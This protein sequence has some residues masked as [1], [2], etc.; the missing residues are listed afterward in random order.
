MIS[1]TLFQSNIWNVWG[2]HQGYICGSM[3]TTSAEEQSVMRTDWVTKLGILNFEDL[4]GRFLQV[5]H[6][7]VGWHW[8]K[9]GR[10]QGCF[11]SW[12]LQTGKNSQYEFLFP[13]L[14]CWLI[15]WPVLWYLISCVM[16]VKWHWFPPKWKLHLPQVQLS[17]ESGHTQALSH[18]RL[19]I[20]SHTS[21]IFHKFSVKYLE[22]V[23]QHQGCSCGSQPS[24]E[25]QS[26]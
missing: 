16:Q 21:D 15:G 4:G 11:C 26:V 20:Q 23:G 6:V 1:S 17:L 12:T 8:S 18:Y 5:L 3:I 10:H 25:E 19:G 13:Y 24:V 7:H 22:W 2:A 9:K 14:Q